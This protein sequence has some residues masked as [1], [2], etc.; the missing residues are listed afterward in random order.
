MCGIAGI[1]SH[2]PALLSRDRLA[3]MTHSLAHRG[4]DGERIWSDANIALG[5]RRLA[6]IDLSDAAS[7]PMYCLNRYSIL[8]NGE[9]YNYIELRDFLERKGY[10]FHTKSDTEVIVAAYDHYGQECLQHF[11]GMFAFSIWDSVEKILFAARDRF[12]EK[13]FF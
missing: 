9:I 10:E 12:G 8:H 13:P 7:Q 5:H 2:D 6:I 1:I 11:D 3:K 4:P